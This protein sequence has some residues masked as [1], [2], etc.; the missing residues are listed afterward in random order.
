MFDLDETLIHTE[1]LSEYKPDSIELNMEGKI[2]YIKINIRPFMY[3]F[4]NEMIK[5]F[6]LCIYTASQDFYAK[7][8]INHIDPSNKYFKL[9]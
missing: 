9:I 8:I 3:E 1:L 6:D 5:L 4:L 2:A 7:A